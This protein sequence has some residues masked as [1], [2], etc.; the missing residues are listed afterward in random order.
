MGPTTNPRVQRTLRR[1]FYSLTRRYGEAIYLMKVQT[2]ST[3][4]SSGD[5]TRTFERVFIRKAVHVPQNSSRNVTFTPAMMQSI[6]NFAW[7]GG[8]GTT[9]EVETFMIA[10]RDLRGWCTIDPT[11]MISWHGSTYQITATQTFDGGV[12][13]QCKQAKGSGPGLWEDAPSWNDCNIWVS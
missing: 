1:T 3:N 6:R 2:G 11:Q 7:Q 4:Y 12:I 5:V 8:A 13:I 9:E 10:A